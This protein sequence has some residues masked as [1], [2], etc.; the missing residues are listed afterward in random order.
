MRL[1]IPSLLTVLLLSG[2]ASMAS[3]SQD[4][5][6]A[7][8]VEEHDQTKD[9]AYERMMRW[10]AMNYVSAQN[11]IQRDDKESG[12]ITLAGMTEFTRNYVATFP[13]RYNLTVDVRDERARFTY[14][15]GDSPEAS[16]L[17]KAEAAQVMEDFEMIRAG[18]MAAVETN[19]D[20]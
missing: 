5:R 17:S 16:G 14:V 7:V 3:A 19:D 15:I 2:C 20:F 11:V 13:I 12:T 9:V 10:V 1:V 6:Q 4:E 18:M 8:V